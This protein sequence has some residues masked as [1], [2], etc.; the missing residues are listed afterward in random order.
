M[1]EVDQSDFYDPTRTTIDMSGSRMIK[2]RLKTKYVEE[3]INELERS[4]YSKFTDFELMQINKRDKEHVEWIIQQAEGYNK[5]MSAKQAAVLVKNIQ[6][7]DNRIFLA[8]NIGPYLIEKDF[9]SLLNLIKAFKSQ[10]SKLTMLEG[11]LPYYD[12]LKKSHIER[13]LGEFEGDYQNEAHELIK[14]NN[15]EFD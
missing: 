4:N 7:E 10:T 11:I 1:F 2:T 6:F 14:D 3:M 5:K 8:K 9:Y 12:L 15:L 13:V